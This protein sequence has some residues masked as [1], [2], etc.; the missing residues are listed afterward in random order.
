MAVLASSA[1]ASRWWA[2]PAVGP[3]PEQLRHHP[4]RQLRPVRQRHDLHRRPVDDRVL[5]AGDPSR[6]AAGR[7]VLRAAAVLHRR[8][9]HDGG[10]LGPADDLPGARDP[11]DLDLRPHRPAARFA[12]GIE[13]A[14]KYFLLGAFSSAFFLYGVALTYAL[15]GSTRL[16]RIGT[17]MAAEGMNVS[18]MMLFALGLLLIGFAFKVSA[19]PFHMWTP[20]AYEGAPTV[21]TGVHV[22]RR[23]GGGLCGVRPGVPVGLRAVARRLDAGAVGPGHGHDGRRHRRRRRAKQH[24]AHAGLLEHR[25]RRVPAGRPGVR[26]RRRQGVDPVLPAGVRRHQPG[27]AR[28]HRAAVD[29]RSASTTSCATSPACGTRARCWPA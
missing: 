8:H 19:V 7:G 6:R 2:A 16:D 18:P 29:A 26:Q 23:E 11:L 22:D 14:F 15:T 25:A 20:D 28:H 5:R 12:A 4:G 13:A 1:S 10:R 3:E 21:V 24:Q 9:D 17:W 27:R